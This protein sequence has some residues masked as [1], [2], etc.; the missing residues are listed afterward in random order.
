MRWEYQLSYSLQLGTGSDNN[1]KTEVII[2]LSLH[3]HSEY[4][5]RI[6]GST[7]LLKGKEDLSH[8]TFNWYLPTFLHNPK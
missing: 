4:E 5:F 7:L 2:P 6:T 3:N 1:T 8:C